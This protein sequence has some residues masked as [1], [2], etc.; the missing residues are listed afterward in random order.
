M[1]LL[2]PG[3]TVIEFPLPAEAAG[4][5][6]D[7]IVLVMRS[8]AGPPGMAGLP[9]AAPPGAVAGAAVAPAPPAAPSPPGVVPPATVPPAVDIMPPVRRAR[10][11]EVVFALYDYPRRT[12]VELAHAGEGRTLVPGAA[13]FVQPSGPVRLRVRVAGPESVPLQQLDLGIRGRLP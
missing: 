3:E 1:L 11:G 6:A 13:A 5:M 9:P 10:A 8:T 4:L 12:W 7:E 2:G